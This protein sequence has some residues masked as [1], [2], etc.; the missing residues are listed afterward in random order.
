MDFALALESVIFDVLPLARFCLSFSIALSCLNFYPNEV[1]SAAGKS[2]KRTGSFW[3]I[4]PSSLL[5]LWESPRP[6]RSLQTENS[7]LNADSVASPIL[8][9]V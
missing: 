7:L 5:M 8:D 3:L 1:G 6:R 9:L 2:G 4:V